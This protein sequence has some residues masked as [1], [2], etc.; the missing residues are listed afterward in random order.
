MQG[1]LNKLLLFGSFY[2]FFVTGVIVLM[3]GA[4][5]PYLLEDFNLSYNMGGLLLS[6]QAVGNL[7]A[8][9]VS[10]FVCVYLGRRAMLILGA[11][12]F[13]IEIGRASCRETV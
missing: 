3:T 2:S 12:A 5:L 4:I 1:K 6:L 7:L 8:G 10:G 13:I 9:V 11:A